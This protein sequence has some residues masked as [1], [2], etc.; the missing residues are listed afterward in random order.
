MG[1][2]NNI[3]STSQRSGIA[4]ER[5]YVDMNPFCCHNELRDRGPE[6]TLWQG[7]MNYEVNPLSNSGP[8]ESINTVTHPGSDKS[9]AD[10][11]ATGA[12]INRLAFFSCDRSLSQR[13]G[14]AVNTAGH[15]GQTSTVNHPA[16]VISAMLLEPWNIRSRLVALDQVVE[17]EC[18]SKCRSGR[19]FAARTRPQKNRFTFSVGPTYISHH[20]YR[21]CHRDPRERR[22]RSAQPSVL[23]RQTTNSSYR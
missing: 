8:V 23:V 4:P 22:T 7:R 9:C 20:R 2:D 19:Q 5:G 3:K 6:R 12:I 10:Q 21:V 15:S 11:L 16:V 17:P 1:K 14:Q 18:P 13:T